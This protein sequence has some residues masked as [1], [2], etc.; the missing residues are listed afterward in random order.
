[1][2]IIIGSNIIIDIPLSAGLYT[3]ALYSPSGVDADFDGIG[4]DP[5]LLHNTNY[6]NS[7]S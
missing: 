1:M 4:D 6:T 2:E 5:S 3:L 7:R